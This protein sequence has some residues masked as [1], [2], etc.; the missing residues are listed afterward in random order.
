MEAEQAFE[1][2]GLGL[3]ARLKGGD[4]AEEANHVRQGQD[5]YQA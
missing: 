3:N 5:A 2:H 4:M 1:R